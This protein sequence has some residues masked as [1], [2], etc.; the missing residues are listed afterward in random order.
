MLVLAGQVTYSYGQ[1]KYIPATDISVLV[2]GNQIRNP[3]TGGFNAPIFSEIDLNGDGVMDLFVF[4]REGNRISTFINNG[5]P[6]QVDYVYAPEYKAKF[7]KDMHD[8]TLLRDFDCDGK[9][10]IFTYSW[11]GGMTVYRND[12]TVQGGLKFN[13]AYN[14]VNS[15]YGTITA[16]LYV[17]SVN[18]PALVDVDFDGD[19]DV[20]TFPVTGN[21]VEFHQ[22]KAKELFNR[23]D[24]LVF[25]LHPSCFGNFGLSGSCNCG[26]LNAGCRLAE[27]QV[28]PMVETAQHGAHSGSC[29]IAVDI[30]GDADY[31]I[32]NGDILGDNML[33]LVNGGNSTTA[34]MTSQDT[35]FPSYNVPVDLFTFPAPY[36]FD[37]NNDGNKDFVVAPCISGPAENFNNVLY[38]QNTT[39]NTTNVFDFQ[40]NRFLVDQMIE[41]GSGAN[42]TFHDV[43]SDGLTDMVIGNFG[44]YSPTLPFVSGLAY[45]RN[46]GTATNPVYS[47]ITDN[48]GGFFSLGLTGLSPAFGD[49]DNDGDADLLLGNTDGTM[50]YYTNTAGPGNFP[51]Y[52][53]AQAAL[54]NNAGSVIDVG[55]F[56][57][58]QIIDVNRD[59][60]PDLLIGERNGNLNYYQNTGSAS[61]PQFTL[62]SDAFGGV[63]VNNWLSLYG[64]SYP[65]LY[66]SAGVYRLLVGAVNGYLYQYDNIDNNLSGTFTLTDSTAYNIF[67][68]SRSTVAVKDITNDGRIEILVGNNAGGV[69]LYKFDTSS[70]IAGPNSPLQNFVLYPNP[71]TSEL[72]IRFN[73]QQAINRNI[74]LFDITGRL[75]DHKTSYSNV[76]LFD[77]SDLPSG[78]YQCRVIENGMVTFT[79]FLVQ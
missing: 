13:L 14:L 24:T 21:F 36:Y 34:N 27:H 37:V 48:F 5:T 29:M 52:T 11:S 20:L 17:A 22:N 47:M 64:Y 63:L 26:I 60:L 8:W 49:L 57:T 75:V 41:V 35:A 56:S 38:Y 67:E 68:P 12:Y 28:P 39:N 45:Y 66:D 62:I 31:D 74:S 15:K 51:S 23:C 1:G 50:V 61:V 59:G 6:N 33:L 42:V 79:K 16:N 55:Q 25:H 54:L 19:L 76:V 40:Q 32:L 18:L 65:C 69:T 73:T 77:V 44:Y 46:T 72:F 10:D 30:D 3:W 9:M 53:L 4:D 78:M 43:D 7:P 70:G 71:A 2:S 58:P